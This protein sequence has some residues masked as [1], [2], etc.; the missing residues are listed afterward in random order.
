MV[1]IV[2][3]FCLSQSRKYHVVRYKGNISEITFVKH[4]WCA[5]HYV[6]HCYSS[7][8]FCASVYSPV[9]STT[10]KMPG[11]WLPLGSMSDPQWGHFQKNRRGRGLSRLEIGLGYWTANTRVPGTWMMAYQAGLAQ[12]AQSP[13]KCPLWPCILL[14]ARPRDF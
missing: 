12:R 11:P 7:R 5:K 2:I 1:I 10:P 6:K 14:H 3:M 13:R 8:R 4:P 9:P